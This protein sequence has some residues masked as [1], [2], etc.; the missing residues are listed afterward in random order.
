MKHF[1]I[2]T[3]KR[4]LH[5]IK[6]DSDVTKIINLLVQEGHITSNKGRSMMDKFTHPKDADV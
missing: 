4:V 2:E 3:L 6:S 5:L 1:N